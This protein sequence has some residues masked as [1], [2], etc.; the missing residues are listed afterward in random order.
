MEQEKIINMRQTSKFQN[1]KALFE[2]NDDLKRAGYDEREKKQIRDTFGKI[3]AKYSGFRV[4]ARDYSSGTGDRMIDLDLRLGPEEVKSIAEDIYSKINLRKQYE[5]ELEAS[6]KAGVFYRDSIAKK[7]EVLNGLLEK[8]KQ[9]AINTPEAIKLQQEIENQKDEISF[10]KM[11]FANA[12]CNYQMAV[13][14]IELL[15]EKVFYEQ[16]IAPNTQPGSNYSKVTA[17]TIE[18]NTKMKSPWTIVVENGLGIREQTQ[19]GGYKIKSGSYKDGKR[20]RLFLSDND[21]RKLFRKAADYVRAWE[22]TNQGAAAKQR[23]EYE[24]VDRENYLANK[25]NNQ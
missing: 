10:A 16:K 7:K 6:K 3:H 1:G 20:I 19:T 11:S 17:L 21:A 2:L 18:Y 14:K 22:A 23:H 5:L 12:Q 9:T 4:V 13:Q 15:S 8:A 24:K 25:N